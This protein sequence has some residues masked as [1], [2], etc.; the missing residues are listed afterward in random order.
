MNYLVMNIG[1]IECGVSSAVVGVFSHKVEAC[2]VAKRL[3][4][5]HN[6]RQGGENEFVVFELPREINTVA[7]EYDHEPVWP[8]ME[9]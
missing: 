2:A 9:R 3:S 7:G 8:P 6:W 5:S 1:C 4:Q